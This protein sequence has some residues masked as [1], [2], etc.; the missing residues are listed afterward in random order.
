M[1]IAAA[2]DICYMLPMKPIDLGLI[3]ARRKKIEAAINELHTTYQSSLRG[4]EDE[5]EELVI[6]ERVFSRLSAG[7][8][9]R[10]EKNDDGDAAH[11]GKPEGLPSMTDMIKEALAHG[12]SVGAEQMKPAALLSYIRGK[13]WPGAA[14]RDVGPIAWRMWQNDQ[15]EKYESGDYSLLEDEIADIKAK[16]AKAAAQAPAKPGE[17]DL[18]GKV[19]P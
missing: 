12:V 15:L 8:P 6:A 7:T 9:A 19:G 4:L 16:I 3:Q 10:A 11:S 18:T 1:H 17:F 5:L 13:Y 14:S 2:A